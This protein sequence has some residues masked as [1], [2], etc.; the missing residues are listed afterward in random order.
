PLSK[1]EERTYE[2][3]DSLMDA[4][5]ADRLIPYINKLTEGKIPIGMFDMDIKRVF[6]YNKYEKLRLGLGLQTNEKIF[7][8]LSVGGWAGWGF[9]DKTWKYGGFVEY[10]PSFPSKDFQIRL[11][12]DKDLRDPGRIHLHHELDRSYLRMLLLASV[13][14]V[15]KLSLSIQRQAGYWQFI[16]TGT[17]ETIKTLYI[18]SYSFSLADSSQFFS[19]EISVQWKYAF[20]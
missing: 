6:R 3:N 20:A 16:L 5:G 4:V 8:K 11:S 9:H 2:F 14:A 15:E 17:K 1:E 13:D 10:T 12:W 19:N 7:R 18:C